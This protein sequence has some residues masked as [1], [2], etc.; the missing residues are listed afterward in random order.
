MIVLL[1]LVS[2]LWGYGVVYVAMVAVVALY[3]IMAYKRHTM[4]G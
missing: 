2:M 1:S 4:E 3:V